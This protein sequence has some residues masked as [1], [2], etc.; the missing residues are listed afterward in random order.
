MRGLFAVPW[1][2]PVRQ[3]KTDFWKLSARRL[4]ASPDLRAPARAKNA[5]GA[6]GAVQVAGPAHLADLPVT[7]KTSQR[8]RPKDLTEELRVMVFVTE[9]VDAPSQAREK[10]CSLGLGWVMSSH[11]LCQHLLQVF[12]RGT[13]IS[14]MELDGL[15]VSQHLTYHDALFRGVWAEQIA[16]EEVAQSTVLLKLVH[17]K[18]QGKGVSKQ[19]PVGIAQSTV[20]LSQDLGDRAAIHL[21]QYVP[22]TFG[23]T[24]GLSNRTA[25]LGHHG[26]HQHVAGKSYADGPLFEDLITQEEQVGAGLASCAGQP[27]D[28]A[29]L[30]ERE[31]KPTHKFFGAQGKG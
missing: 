13:G 29:A 20:N 28:L 12:T 26:V 25:A 2:W 30:G 7:E 15:V 18:P 31:V 5:E 22:A 24:H 6:G 8:Q 9:E 17:D 16:D 21:H 3:W 23:D 27:S 1:R 11:V 4:R 14:Q 10:Q 19:L